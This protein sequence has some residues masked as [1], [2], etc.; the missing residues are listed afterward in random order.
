MRTRAKELG[1]DHLVAEIGVSSP[2]KEGGRRGE[3]VQTAPYV[4]VSSLWDK[5]HALLG[6]H[7][8]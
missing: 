1:Q 4:Y 7:E 3:K 5:I 8:R 2:L 6:Q